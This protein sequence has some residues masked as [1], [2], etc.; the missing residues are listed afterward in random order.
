MGVPPVALLGLGV[1]E[2]GVAAFA[3]V[4]QAYAVEQV[5]GDDFLADANRSDRAQADQVVQRGDAST[6]AVVQ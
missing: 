1:F 6:R 4:V 3:G 5:A 2:P